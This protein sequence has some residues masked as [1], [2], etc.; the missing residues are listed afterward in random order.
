MQSNWQALT[1]EKLPIS[2]A[3]VSFSLLFFL[4]LLYMYLS[5]ILY[6]F[7]FF[8]FFLLSLLFLLL[9][10]AMLFSKPQLCFVFFPYSFHSSNICQWVKDKPPLSPIQSRLTILGIWDHTK[11]ILKMCKPL[12]E[13]IKLL[14]TKSKD[15]M[16]Q[17][18]EPYFLN[19]KFLV[20]SRLARFHCGNKLPPNVSGLL[21][22][23][24]G[25]HPTWACGL[26]ITAQESWRSGSLSSQ[27][28]LPSSLCREGESWGFFH[29]QSKAL[30][31]KLHT[32]PLLTTTHKPHGLSTRQGA[33]LCSLHMSERRGCPTLGDTNS[34][35]HSIWG[36][37]GWSE[38]R[39]RPQRVW[40]LHL[41][42]KCGQRASLRSAAARPHSRPLWGCFP[43]SL[44]GC[45]IP[46]V[47]QVAFHTGS[48]TWRQHF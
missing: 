47:R 34:V 24:D 25:T 19:K 16:T 2:C 46:S 20:Y 40:L 36:Q 21:F 33:K 32:V 37:Q 35:H 9:H 23:A 12:K 30:A 48:C 28:R 7:C 38:D 3:A 44:S 39:G 22:L 31:W 11:R 41:E 18:E 10:Y 26:S 14:K 43:H 15:F 13:W 1:W 27:H 42:G 29:W 4:Y 8:F 5:F 45:R 17:N 6:F